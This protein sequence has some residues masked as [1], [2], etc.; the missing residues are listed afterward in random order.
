MRTYYPNKKQISELKPATSYV[1][2]VRAENSHGIS[3]PSGVSSVIRTLGVENGVVPQSE[4]AA[5]RAV[6]SGKVIISIYKYT[7]Y[8]PRK[9]PP[10]SII[11]F[12]EVITSN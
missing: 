12:K 6:L 7:F 4:L 10:S 8:T 2:L 11:V 3:V 9:K 1:F 5:A